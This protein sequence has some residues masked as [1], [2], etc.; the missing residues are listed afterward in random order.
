MIYYQQWKLEESW[1]N[2]FFGIDKGV[3]VPTF[4]PGASQANV[5]PPERKGHLNYELLKT[6]GLTKETLIDGDALFFFQLLLPIC[7]PAKSGIENDPRLPYYSKVAKWTQVY[8]TNLGLGGSYGHHYKS[9]M[10][11]EL[12]R[13]DGCLMRDGVLNGSTDGAI[14]R[15]WDKSDPNFSPHMY[16]R[17]LQLK[18][19]R[20]ENDNST[21]KKKG[22]EG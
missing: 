12:I 6:M 20:N 22:E 5:L 16:E 11:P 3:P 14:Y 15:R 19:T 8:A 2:D 13:Y 10:I 18:R 17:F 4:R 21:A 9:V 7:D 1:T